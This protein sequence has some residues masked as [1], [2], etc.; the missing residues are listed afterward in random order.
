MNSTSCENPDKVYY[1]LRFLCLLSFLNFFSAI[2]FFL[3]R[4]GRR[5]IAINL[6]FCLPY[7]SIRGFSS[8]CICAVKKIVLTFH[9]RISF[10]FHSE[11]LLSLTYKLNNI[12]YF[13]THSLR[14]SHYFLISV[15]ICIPLFLCSA[16]SPQCILILYFL[17]IIFSSSSC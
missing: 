5:V 17:P 15:K 8:L 1:Q 3:L 13:Q 16:Y 14:I 10:Y 4:K 2:F 6:K 11:S 7:F 9:L 12:L